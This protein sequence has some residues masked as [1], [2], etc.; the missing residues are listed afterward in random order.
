MS[1]VKI[2]EHVILDAAAEEFA[3]LGYDGARVDS[4]ARIAGV[5]KAT[6]YYRVGDKEE[7]YR[8]VVLRGQAVF[9]NAVIQAIENSE[10]A[11]ETVTNILKEIA[12]NALENIL[13]P[14][15][16][17][18]EIAGNAK[19]LPQEG[20]DGLKKFM[21]TT[22]AI[23]TM[24]IEDGV[25]RDVDPTALQFMI[26]GAIFSLSLTSRMRVLVNS[27]NPGPITPDQIAVSI[28]DIL[29]NGLLK[30]GNRQ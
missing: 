1:P 2:E 28:S 23:V 27:D 29:L 8:R 10:T 14:S 25:F 5:N 3:K 26:T 21:D 11:T 19:T 13:I 18:R 17:L 9:H 22:R 20:L 6:L 15:I 16:I 12:N 24:G 30:E 4:I 7:L